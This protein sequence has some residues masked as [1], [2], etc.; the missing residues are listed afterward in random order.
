VGSGG[1]CTAAGTGNISDPAGLP[2]GDSV[3]YT[4]TCDVA[5]DAFGSIDNTASVTPPAT[6]SESNGTNN[7]ATDSDL[8]VTGAA[9]QGTKV[10]SGAFV[11]G[12]TLTYTIVLTNT[13]IGPQAD[14]PGDE[15]TDVLPAELELLNATATSGNAFPDLATNTVTWNGSIAAG[16]SVTLTITADILPSAGNLNVSNQGTISF[17]GDGDGVNDASALTDDPAGPTDS[18]PTV[19]VAGIPASEI[20]VLSPFALLLLAGLLAMASAWVLGRR[21]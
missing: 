15:F 12:S 6:V 21:P 13:G 8:V 2:A 9:V 17:D 3:T 14:A 11:V 20:P 4:V 1:T 10:A 18:D 19:I 16:A 5:D 7:S